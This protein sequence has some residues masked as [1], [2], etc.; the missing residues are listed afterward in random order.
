MFHVAQD[1][2]TRGN[3]GY[4]EMPLDRN[5]SLPEEMKH[6]RED[7]SALFFSSLNFSRKEWFEAK[8]NPILCLIKKENAG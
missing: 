8:N 1:K 2:N 3:S 6:A 5:L 4:K 7:K